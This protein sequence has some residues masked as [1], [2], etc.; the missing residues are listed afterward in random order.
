MWG[1]WLYASFGLAGGVSK[2]HC[3]KEGGREEGGRERGRG[4]GGHGYM[5]ASG[6]PEGWRE[7]GGM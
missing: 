1:A 7:E 4:C 5:L 2:L 3:G 6:L